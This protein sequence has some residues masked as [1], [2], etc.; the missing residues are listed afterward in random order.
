MLPGIAC[1]PLCKTPN[2][3][4]KKISYI[5]ITSLNPRN[6]IG[7]FIIDW[8]DDDNDDDD[9]DDDDCDNDDNNDFDVK[10]NDFLNVNNIINK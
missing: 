7:I 2:W 3:S 9:D 8:Y 5:L 4:N 10:L 6:L 1:L